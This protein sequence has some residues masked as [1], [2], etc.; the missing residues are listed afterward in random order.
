MGLTLFRDGEPV[1]PLADCDLLY[2][3]RDGS[4]AS[5]AAVLPRRVGIAVDR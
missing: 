5:S 1:P 2:P 4:C 3:P